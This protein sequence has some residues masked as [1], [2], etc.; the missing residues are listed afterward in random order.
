MTEDD[1]ARP[2]RPGAPDRDDVTE[3]VGAPERTE[4]SAGRVS[5]AGETAQYIDDRWTKLFVA[6]TIVV[7]ALIFAN[8]IFLGQGGLLTTTPSPT[9]I[10][11]ASPTVEATASP[12]PS[13]SASPTPIPSASASPTPTAPATASPSPL[14]TL[15]PT[16]A[17]T[18]SETPS[19]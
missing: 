17:P 12:I 16:S 1:E 14:A 13:A 8:A 7:F 15:T 5:P 10:P 9:P 4:A 2:L 19:P 6:V 18:A 11:T 3:R